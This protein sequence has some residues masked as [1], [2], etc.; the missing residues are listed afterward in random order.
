MT[1]VAPAGPAAPTLSIDEI[2]ALMEQPRGGYAAADEID[3][4]IAKPLQPRWGARLL[5]RF[6][7]RHPRLAEIDAVVAIAHDPRRWQEASAA[8]RALRERTLE[9]E[10]APDRSSYEFLVL[11]ED[12]AKTTANAIPG[13]EDE[14]FRPARALVMAMSA[15]AMAL[16][17]A[18][19]ALILD[20][21]QLVQRRD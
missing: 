19:D 18:D 1:A 15:R 8:F 3:R 5:E 13:E 12:L 2:A 21:E 20:I 10:Q 7:S 17:S 6:Q 9:M 14:S 16:Q 11:A 4:R